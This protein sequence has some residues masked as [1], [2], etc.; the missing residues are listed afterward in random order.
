MVR[1]SGDL[2]AVT[3]KTSQ[4]C[5]GGSEGRMSRHRSSPPPKGEEEGGTAGRDRRGR[6]WLVKELAGGSAKRRVDGQ[7]RSRVM[8][9]ATC[10][11]GAI[12]Q[13]HPS[14]PKLKGAQEPGGIRE[15]VS[16]PE[17]LPLTSQCSGTRQPR[18]TSAGEIGCCHHCLCRK[19]TPQRLVCEPACAPSRRQ[20]PALRPPA[21]VHQTLVQLFWGGWP[22]I[23]N[24]RGRNRRDERRLLREPGAGGRVAGLRV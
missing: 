14:P 16:H 21:S 9:G 12:P 15:L 10:V 11:A 8:W 19:A 18:W 20:P 3:C 2:L 23:L 1:P 17:L 4:L 5:G 7:L 24:R 6:R 22:G 13:N